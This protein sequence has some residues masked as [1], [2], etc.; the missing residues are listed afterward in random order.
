MGYRMFNANITIFNKVYDPKTRSDK[1]VRKVLKGVHVEKTHTIQKDDSK[2]IVNDS[3]FVSIPFSDE[4]T[5]PKKFQETKEGYTIQNRDVI[6]VGIVEKN[7]ESLK[8]LKDMDD[9][10]TVNSVEVIDYSKGL[11]HIE[12][13]AS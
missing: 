6:V 8:D 10:Y 4:Y 7:I 3:L 13:Y 12:V 1:Y 2:V 5:S 9:I 11:N